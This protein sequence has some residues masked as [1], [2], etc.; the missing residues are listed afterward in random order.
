[1]AEPLTPAGRRLLRRLVELDG[2]DAATEAA[3][4]L[5]IEQ[6]AAARAAAPLDEIRCDFDCPY[7]WATAEALREAD[8]EL[9]DAREWLASRGEAPEVQERL[10]NARLGLAPFLGETADA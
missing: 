1:M 8:F 3:N 2:F 7:V 10:I 9:E 5:A 6:E 4:I